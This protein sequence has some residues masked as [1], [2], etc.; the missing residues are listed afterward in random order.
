LPQQTSPSKIVV[1]AIADSQIGITT[2]RS[3]LCIELK[4]TKD[5]M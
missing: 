4:M 3:Q 2:Y 5:T 1:P